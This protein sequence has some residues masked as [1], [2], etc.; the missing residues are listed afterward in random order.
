AGF[1][2]LLLGEDYKTYGRQIKKLLVKGGISFEGK[3]SIKELL[4]ISYN[5]LLSNYRHEYIY[6]TSLLNAYILQKYSLKDSVILNE[7]KVGAS[8]ADVVLVNGTNKVFEIK[9]EL[10]SPERLKTQIADYYKVFSEVFIVTHHS[11]VNKYKAVLEEKVG[12]I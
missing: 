8:K 12:I 3:S 4:D 5:H 10:D 11:L 7:F 2:R 9:T 6:K 1:K